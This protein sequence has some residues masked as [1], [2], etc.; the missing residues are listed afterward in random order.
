MRL[1]FISLPFL[2]FWSC[3]TSKNSTQNNETTVAVRDTSAGQKEV[4]LIRDSIVMPLTGIAHNQKGGAVVVVDNVT[5][6]IDG[7]LSWEDRYAGNPVRVWG[8]VIVRNDNPVFLDTGSVISQG[9]PVES[10]KSLRAHQQRFW[11]INARY[12]LL[13]P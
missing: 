1:L 2:V 10:E 12:E 7:L 11:I 5:Y 8:E 4:G 9:I 6:W 3:T 13:R